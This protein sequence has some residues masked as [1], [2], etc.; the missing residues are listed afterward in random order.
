M[1]KEYDFS[2]YGI[3]K[4]N[5][6][7]LQTAWNEQ[8][9]VVDLNKVNYVFITSLTSTPWRQRERFPNAGQSTLFY[10]WNKY[11][12]RRIK[13]SLHWTN[14][15]QSRWGRGIKESGIFGQDPFPH[16]RFPLRNF[17]V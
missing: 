12:D 14:D 16:F 8:K 3:K 10:Y 6:P 2:L 15:S 7:Q 4:D 5:P 17:I 1:E 13:C 11:G 9:R